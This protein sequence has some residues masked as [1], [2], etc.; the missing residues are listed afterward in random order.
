MQKP[1]P[2]ASQ[3]FVTWEEQDNVLLQV[4]RHG[5]AVGHDSLSHEHR[6][7]ERHQQRVP[8]EDPARVIGPQVQLRAMPM[9]SL[10]AQRSQC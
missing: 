9:A 1:L 7:G 6:E 4:G 2:M 10:P 8:V 3:G 5:G